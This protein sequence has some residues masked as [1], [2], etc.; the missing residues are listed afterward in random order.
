VV[1]PAEYIFNPTFS[2]RFPSVSLD[3]SQKRGSSTACTVVRGATIR[4]RVRDRVDHT[5][6]RTLGVME[7]GQVEPLMPRVGR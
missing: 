3:T 1:R 7:N 5:A 6:R 4:M 2:A